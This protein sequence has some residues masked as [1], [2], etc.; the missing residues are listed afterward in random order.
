V[1]VLPTPAEQW[2]RKKCY[3]TFFLCH[4]SRVLFN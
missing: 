4:L 1:P 3:K 2:T